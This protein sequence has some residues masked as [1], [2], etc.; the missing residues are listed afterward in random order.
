MHASY[1]EQPGRP[2]IY[3]FSESEKYEQIQDGSV[4]FCEMQGRHRKLFW[5][6]LGENRV[7][8]YNTPPPPI[9]HCISRLGEN[10]G[11]QGWVSQNTYSR[12]VDFNMFL[13]L[14]YDIQCIIYYI[15]KCSIQ[16]DLLVG[17]VRFQNRPIALCCLQISHRRI[18]YAVI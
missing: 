3:I 12:T 11:G 9:L 18:I 8:L 10:I 6:E 4:R 1:R 14:S 7:I 13:F 17:C 15:T 2:V 5:V 16:I